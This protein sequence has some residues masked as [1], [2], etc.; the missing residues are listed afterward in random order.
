MSPSD[1]KRMLCH[2]LL[3]IVSL[4]ET[5]MVLLSISVRADMAEGC[6]QV[7]SGISLSKVRIEVRAKDIV[8]SRGG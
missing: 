8:K 3:A 1:D 7:F 4:M 2:C 6:A 5:K